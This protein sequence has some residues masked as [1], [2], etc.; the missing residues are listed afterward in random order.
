MNAGTI[1]GRLAHLEGAYDQISDRLNGM[2][3]RFESLERKLDDFA[4]STD[5]RFDSLVSRMDRQFFWLMGI[6]LL[7]IVL[8]LV[9]RLAGR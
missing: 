2:D 4:R 8:P 9:G 5:V 3:R 1:D 6:M 7:S